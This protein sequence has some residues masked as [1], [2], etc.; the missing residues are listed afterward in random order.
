VRTKCLYMD[1][2]CDK[3]LVVWLDD[4][5]LVMISGWLLHVMNLTRRR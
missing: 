3:G 1:R 5:A 2:R 4:A